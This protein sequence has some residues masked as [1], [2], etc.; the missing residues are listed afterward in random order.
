MSNYLK[1]LS[2]FRVLSTLLTTIKLVILLFLVAPFFLILPPRQVQAATTTQFSQ[3]CGNI[4]VPGQVHHIIWIWMENESY[5]KI[6]GNSAAPYQNTLASQCGIATN[7]YNESHGSL[8][9]YIAAT[10]GQSPLNTSFLKDCLPNA[11]ADYCVSHN[12]NI[13]SEAEAAGGNWRGYAEDMPTNC[14]ITNTGNY[15]ARHNPAVYY[16]ELTNCAIYDIPM[17]D[18]TT[19]TGQ[20]YDDVRNGTLPSFTFVIP[21]LIDDAHSSDTTT[22]DTWLSE[23]IPF[24]TNNANYQTGDTVIFITNDEGSG[25]DQIN[26]EDC[27]NQSLSLSQPSCH[28]PTIVI[29]PYITAGTAVNTFYTHYSMLKTAEELLGYPL[30]GLAQ[31]A[32]S[33]ANAFNL[34]PTQDITP[35]PPTVP[36]NLIATAV[37][38]SQVNLTWSGSTAGT[39]PVNSYQIVR[40]GSI[41]ATTKATSYSDLSTTGNT[42]YTYTVNAIDAANDLSP[43]SSAVMV[44][45]PSQSSTQLLPNPGF[46]DWTNGVPTGWSTYGPATT[47]TQLTDAHAGNYSVGI[48]TTKTTYA[49][50]GVNAVN[51][52]TPLINS[53]TAG[54]S[55][56][57]SCWVKASKIITLNIQLHEVTQN[58]A[59]VSPAAITSLK[60]P[61]VN[62][63]Y[64]IQVNYTTIGNGNMLPFSIY[65]TNTIAGGATFQVDNCVLKTN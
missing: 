13:F 7:F 26:G 17:G 52:S 43:S 36:T 39:F 33:M 57:G 18:I 49:A 4:G 41:I 54:T 30:L 11:L 25:T 2:V 20:F 14:N 9:N 24:I 38:S 22:G 16:P 65:S 6:I 55:Y 63:W 5:N 44:T 21:N 19:Q 35:T 8:S 29:A 46:E 34:G 51:G 32:N 59:S 40:N 15:A 50:S 42:S 60:V 64:Q 37:S 27:A 58:W 48:A 1:L 62:T 23:L 56:T 53:T 10:D 45:T 31:T 12:A 3:P 47:L 28:I 61:A